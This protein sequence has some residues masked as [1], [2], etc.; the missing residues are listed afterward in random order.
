MRLKDNAKYQLYIIHQDH[1]EKTYNK[2]EFEGCL[3]R[4]LISVGAAIKNGVLI[5]VGTSISAD[6]MHF[7]ITHIMLLEAG[8][9]Y[10][11]KNMY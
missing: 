3:D 4:L 7:E 6:T 10:S 2:Q 8:V 1:M 5:S 11:V 9:L